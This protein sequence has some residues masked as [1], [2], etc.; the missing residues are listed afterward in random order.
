MPKSKRADENKVVGLLLLVGA[1]DATD[2]NLT[3]SQ[4]TGGETVDLDDQELQPWLSQS[5]KSTI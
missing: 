1:A 5:Q 3:L 4:N 2:L